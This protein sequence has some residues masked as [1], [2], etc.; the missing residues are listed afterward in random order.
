MVGTSEGIGGIGVRVSM[1]VEI[2]VGTVVEDGKNATTARSVI[3]AEVLKL[4]IATSTIFRGSRGMRLDLFIPFRAIAATL[5]NK[6]I[7]NAPALSMV[8]G[9]A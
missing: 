3:T 4:E 9:A 6:P 5:Q 2:C 1:M 7:P 8:S